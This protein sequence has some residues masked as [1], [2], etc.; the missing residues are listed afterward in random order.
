MDRRTS[1]PAER[2]VY[3]SFGDDRLADLP[4]EQLGLL[5]EEYYRRFPELRGRETVWWLGN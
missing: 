2:A 3:L 4:V 5:L 1:A